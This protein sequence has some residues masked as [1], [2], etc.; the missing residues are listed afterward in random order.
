MELHIPY[1]VVILALLF[2][3]PIMISMMLAPHTEEGFIN[4]RESRR[5]LQSG[6]IA[7]RKK[8]RN[9]K[10]NIRELVRNVVKKI[11]IV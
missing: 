2:I 7:I 9:V 6:K 10:R 5:K 3:F 11:I 1:I 4:I 8:M